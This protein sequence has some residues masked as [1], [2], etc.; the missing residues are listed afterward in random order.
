[1]ER[2]GASTV[3]KKGPPT[4]YRE[5]EAGDAKPDDIQAAGVSGGISASEDGRTGRS[6]G[7][8]A[9]LLSVAQADAPGYPQGEVCH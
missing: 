1:M 7:E 2:G 9:T 3:V 8:H 4:P 6:A 5:H